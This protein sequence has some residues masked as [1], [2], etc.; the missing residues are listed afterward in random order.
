MSDEQEKSDNPVVTGLVALLAVSLAVGLV[1]GG[2]A[3]VGTRILGIGG[4]SS[5]ST[6]ASEAESAVIP[7]PSKTS[8]NGPQVTLNTQDAESDDTEPGDPKTT[9]TEK[10]KPEK[11]IT[12]QAGQTAV[13]NFEQIDLTGVYPGGEGA[14]LQVQRFEG[15][16]WVDF[17]ATLSVSNETFSTYVQSAQIG[18][19]KF[20]VVDSATGAASN[21]VT[22]TVG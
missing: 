22:V 10:A 1:L 20:R 9:K 21:P 5:G 11:E 16:Q 15:G 4:D 12:L 2:V 13:G 19:N 14:I 6:G 8:A 18:V 3:L 17:N 7:R